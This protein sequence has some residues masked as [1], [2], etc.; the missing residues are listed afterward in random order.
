M[1]TPKNHSS[2]IPFSDRERHRQTELTEV[3]RCVF[4]CEHSE[5]STFGSVLVS[6]HRKTRRYTDGCRCTGEY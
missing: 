3:P 6:D 1:I 4:G 2:S 5:E